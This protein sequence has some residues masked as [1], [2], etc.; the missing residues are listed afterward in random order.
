ME[1]L[2]K[3]GAGWGEGRG[4]GG[5]ERVRQVFGVQQKQSQ[6]PAL[7]TQLLKRNAQN[8]FNT[9]YHILKTFTL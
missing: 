7:N 9:V 5:Q 3:R 1:P 2:G 6:T 8:A 4:A